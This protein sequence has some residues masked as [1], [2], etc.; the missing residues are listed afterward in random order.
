[1]GSGL[2]PSFIQMTVDIRK[3]KLSIIIKYWVSNVMH[4][5]SVSVYEQ[6]KLIQLGVRFFS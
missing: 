5:L 6:N 3:C 2:V 4:D 1:M